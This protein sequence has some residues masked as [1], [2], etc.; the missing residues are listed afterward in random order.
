MKMS[1]TEKERERGRGKEREG[2][3]REISIKTT[4]RLTFIVYVNTLQSNFMKNFTV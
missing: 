3:S 2:E 1:A 4:Y